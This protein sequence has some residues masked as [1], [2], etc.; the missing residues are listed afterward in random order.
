MNIER[1]KVYRETRKI[2]MRRKNKKDTEKEKENVQT[3]ENK[4]AK[5]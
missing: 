3:I 2:H 4:E 1:G 5:G